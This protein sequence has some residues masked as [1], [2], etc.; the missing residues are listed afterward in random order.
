M[1]RLHVYIEKKDVAEKLRRRLKGGLHNKG[2]NEP[3]I[4]IHSLSDDFLKVILNKETLVELGL[5]DWKEALYLTDNAQFASLLVCGE[6]PVLAYLH[7]G[8]RD[9]SFEKV[10]YVIEGFEDI[11]WDYFFKVWQRLTGKPWHIL[12]TERCSVRETT[13][14]DVDAFYELYREPSI[15]AYMENLYADRQ[16]EKAYIQTYTEKV[17][18]FYGFGMW[19]V[20]SKGTG[21]I[22]G[23]AGISMREGFDDPELGFMIGVPWQGQGIAREVCNG[24]LQY[25]KEELEFHRVQA[26]VKPENQ[27]SIGLL[28]KLGFCFKE[29][30]ILEDGRYHLYIL[31]R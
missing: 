25:A 2:K 20:L 3:E 29:E 1:K 19:T 18:G 8:N 24:I 15:T 14:E 21:Q 23:R 4:C 12:D 6:Y 28:G 11:E 16:E 30:T 5:S 13:V 7:D 9:K 27:K 31:E 26:L 17:Y 22:I 10:N